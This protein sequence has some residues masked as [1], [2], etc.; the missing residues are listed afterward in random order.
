MSIKVIRGAL[1]ETPVGE[2][3]L[4]GVI[5]PESL[6]A[7]Q[8]DD[9][10]REVL[11]L[12][13]IN[14]LVKAFETG[15]VPDIELGMRG[16]H[17]VERSPHFYL[18]DST[19]I[20]DGLQRVTAAM[21]IVD[22]GSD[23]LPSVG[24]KIHFGTTVDWEREQF[25]I[26]NQERLKLSPNILLR[27][28][29]HDYG[30]IAM[31]YSLSQDPNFVLGQRVAW[32]QRMLRKELITATTFAKIVARLHAHFGPGKSTRID[33]VARGLES[34]Q[35]VV[36]KQIMRGNVKTFFESVDNAYGIRRVQFKQGATFMK[37]AYLMSLARVYS[38]H[39]DFWRGDGERHLFIEASLQRK[40]AQFPYSDP[41]VVQLSSSGGKASEILYMLMVD[42][43]NSGRRT[44]RLKPRMLD[45]SEAD[46]EEADEDEAAA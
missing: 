33:Q 38:N 1:D 43:I 2:I 11:P 40:I 46:A 19:Y 36:G 21:R 7:L 35:G 39:T 4:R 22:R 16:Q 26:L 10:Q 17:V 44:R 5:A 18:Q 28:W 13:S 41:Q 24:A 45:Y 37:G 25:R 42:H 6:R 9:Y 27:N 12:A 15:S 3:I 23:I 32:S 14:K 31:L 20:I 34:V 8:V 29:R 30:A